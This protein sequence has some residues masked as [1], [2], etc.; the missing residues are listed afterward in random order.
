MEVSFAD[1]SVMP[2]YL[3]VFNL[4]FHLTLG[5]GLFSRNGGEKLI[6]MA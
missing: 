6:A 1:S 4:K 2:V 3:R 5:K